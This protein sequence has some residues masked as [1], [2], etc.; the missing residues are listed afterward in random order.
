MDSGCAM[1]RVLRQ[2]RTNFH[3]S[4]RDG[5]RYAAVLILSRASKWTALSVAP[6]AAHEWWGPDAYRMLHLAV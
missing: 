2:V 4:K 1:R 5:T 6:S 3:S